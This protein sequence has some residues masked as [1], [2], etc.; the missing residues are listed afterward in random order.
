MREPVRLAVKRMGWR[1]LCMSENNMADRAH[2][3][4][5]YETMEKRTKEDNLLPVALKNAIATIGQSMNVSG[6]VEMTSHKQHH[7]T[8]ISTNQ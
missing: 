8:T 6:L 5:I 1:E 7:A 3:L 2:F 4:R